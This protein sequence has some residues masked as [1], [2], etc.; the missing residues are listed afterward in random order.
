[1]S[2]LRMI[3]L[4]AR[5]SFSQVVPLAKMRLNRAA[6]SSILCKDESPHLL[7][8]QQLLKAGVDKPFV[9]GQIVNIF[10]FAIHLVIVAAIQLCFIAQK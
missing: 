4:V 5:N 9:K 3:L 7:H 1:M 8:A 6:P 2:L 10:S